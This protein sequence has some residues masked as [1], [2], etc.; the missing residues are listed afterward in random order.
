MIGTGGAIALTR[1]MANMVHGVSTRDP[2]TFAMGILLV[3]AVA[4]AA[5][6]IPAL[7]AGRADPMEI[8]RR[9]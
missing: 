7:R 8:L 5:S 2:M 9:E 4:L 3:I 6:W 1:L